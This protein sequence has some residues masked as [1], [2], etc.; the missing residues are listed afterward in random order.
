MS[1]MIDVGKGCAPGQSFHLGAYFSPGRIVRCSVVK[2]WGG[3]NEGNADAGSKGR[4]KHIDLEN[5]W[6]YEKK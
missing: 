1:G 6:G 3:G 2:V 5:Y 4:R